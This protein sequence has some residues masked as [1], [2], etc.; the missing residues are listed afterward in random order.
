MISSMRAAS[1]TVEA[2]GA[3]WS[4]VHDRGTMPSVGTKPNVGLRPTTPHNALGTRM[5]ARV[6]VPIDARPMPHATA[7]AD[8]PDDPPGIDEDR[9]GWR[10]GGW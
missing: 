9:T 4:M 6:S 7:I 5:D 1:A 8:P 3:T 10:S 2:I